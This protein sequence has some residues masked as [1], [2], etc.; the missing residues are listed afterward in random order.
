MD[1]YNEQQL[2][3]VNQKCLN[4]HEGTISGSGKCFAKYGASVNGINKANSLD[5]IFGR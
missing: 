2:N 5:F 1:K 3:D 4:K